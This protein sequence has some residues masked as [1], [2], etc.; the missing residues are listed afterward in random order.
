MVFFALRCLKKSVSLVRKK[1]GQIKSTEQKQS[2][3]EEWTTQKEALQSS[4][5]AM[6]VEWEK[7]E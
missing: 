5:S 2:E 3:K 1:C 6:A 4:S 7:E